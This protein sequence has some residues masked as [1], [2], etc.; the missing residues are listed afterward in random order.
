MNKG[1]DFA[2]QSWCSSKK[3]LQLLRDMNRERIGNKRDETLCAS[4]KEVASKMVHVRPLVSYKKE[5]P[6]AS[7]DTTI[8]MKIFKINRWVR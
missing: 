5:H 4:L 8:T 2:S 1:Q 3:K 6:W 7:R